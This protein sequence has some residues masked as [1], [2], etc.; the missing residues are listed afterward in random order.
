MLYVTERFDFDKVVL[1]NIELGLFLDKF[2]KIAFANG[3]LVLTNTIKLVQFI[4]WDFFRVNFHIRTRIS[5]WT[6]GLVLLK[7]LEYVLLLI[8]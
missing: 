2:F 5:S 8:P 7:R 1:Y 3:K 6:S 4:D